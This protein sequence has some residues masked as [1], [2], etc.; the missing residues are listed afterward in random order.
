MPPDLPWKTTKTLAFLGLFLALPYLSPKFARL[1]L[2]SQRAPVEAEITEAPEEELAFGEAE[3][4]VETRERPEMAQ[5]SVRDL[6]AALP[7]I[8]EEKPPRPIEDPS[9]VAMDGF[10]RALSRTERELPGALTRI[11]HFGDSILVSD[12]V[13]GTLRRRMQERF[14]DGG[15]GFLL[16][17]A[18]W[19]GYFHNDVSHTASAGWS[20]SRVVGPLT[21]D[22]F[23]GLGGVSFRSH[24]PGTWAR[25]A[26]NQRGELGSRASRFVVS[27]LEQPRGGDFEVRV[28]G[29]SRGTISTEGEAPRSRTH[30]VDVEDGEHRFE[31]RLKRGQVRA[32]GV[33]LEREGPGVVYDSIGILGARMRALSQNDE[34]HFVEQLRLR[35]PQLLVFQ[36]GINESEDGFSFSSERLEGQVREVLERSKRALPEASCLVIG[37]IDRADRQGGQLVSRK[38]IPVLVEAQRRAALGGGCAFFDA[39]EAMGGRGSMGEWRRKGLGGHDLAH[40][41]SSGAEVLG[42]WIYRALLE[43]YG[44]Y[45]KRAE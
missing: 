30:Q 6:L 37:A 45:R 24:R 29:E 27:Y 14:G 12:W 13:T 17:A 31:L 39:Y 20:L 41:S 38:F 35:D 22:G 19:P 36:Y 26:T 5:P 40:P 23:Y 11:T 1:Q 8:E 43:G 32:F 15:H 2:L 42:T 9:G 16:I 3:L 44:E 10:Y 4:T 34:A 21:R 28:D 25:F 18:G 7:F 33:W